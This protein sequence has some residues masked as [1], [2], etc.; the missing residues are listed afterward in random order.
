MAKICMWATHIIFTSTVCKNKIHLF[1]VLNVQCS[2]LLSL[3]LEEAIKMH[4]K[5]IP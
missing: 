5:S 1:C 4:N 3:E 2:F